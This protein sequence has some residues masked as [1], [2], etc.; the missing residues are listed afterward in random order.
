MF[1]AYQLAEKLRTKKAKLK[2]SQYDYSPSKKL[3]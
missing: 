3:S 1:K 2:S